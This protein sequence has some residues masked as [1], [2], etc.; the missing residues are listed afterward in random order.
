M[1]YINK[2]L[3]SK[4]SILAFILVVG[5]YMSTGISFAGEVYT[6]N[7]HGHYSHP[8]TGSI[9]DPGNNPGIGEGMVSN[10]VYGTALIEKDD[11]GKLY[12]TVRYNLRDKI[13]KFSFIV[14][15]KGDSGWTEVP[16]QE[17]QNSG[18]T[19]DFRFEIPS[20]DCI[21]RATFF[22]D[23]MARSVVFYINFDDL[24]AG[25]T[26]FKALVS[27]GGSSQSSGGGSTASSQSSGGTSSSSNS[28]GSTTKSSSPTK[29]ASTSP[30][31]SK[32]SGS[33]TP[34]DKVKSLM[35]SS[36]KVTP[37]PGSTSID[38]VAPVAGGESDKKINQ[39]DL[40]YDHGLLTNKDFGD[41][42]TLMDGQDEDAPWGIV[43]KVLFTIIVVLLAI[44]LAVILFGAIGLVLGFKYLKNKNYSISENL[45]SQGFEFDELEDIEI[46]CEPSGV[47]GYE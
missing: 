1:Q 21:V 27:T 18:A 15:K 26:D 40:G 32:A 10:V 20:A 44:I 23:P 24:Q 13:S 11:D 17:T 35:A 22:V 42:K 14:Q 41:S 36:N 8:V 28:G 16:Y 33:T 6:A 19:G 30:S 3:F 39:G 47:A 43:T 37:K 45:E 38:G 25:N 5:L 2:K 7:A 9:E 34:N 46:L 29:Q 12:A 31:T 4:L